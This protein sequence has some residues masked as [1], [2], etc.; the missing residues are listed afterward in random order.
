[1]P[2][3]IEMPTEPPP[4]PQ[5]WLSI[6]RQVL[7]NSGDS[8]TSL[9]A[10]GC[11]FYATLSLFP[12]LTALISVY[13]LAFDVQTAESQLHV[14]KHILPSAAYD[15]IFDRVHALV[16]Q[17]QSS[18]TLGLV[19][20]VLVALWSVTASS[21]SILS[22]LN[23]VYHTKEARGFLHFQCLAF[24]TTLMAVIGACLTLAL[25]VAAPAV[26]DYLPRY[27][28]YV[29][30]TMDNFPPSLHFLVEQGT[31][32]LVHWLAPAIM[33]CFVFTAL[34]VLYR[35]APCREHLTSWR[36]IMPGALLATLLWVAVSIG[37]SWYVSHFASYGTTYGPLGAVA[38]VMM[39]LFVSAYVVLFGAVLNAEL[40]ERGYRRTVRKEMGVPADGAEC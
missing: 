8:Q 39:W 32:V 30:V 3:K 15:M 25:M 5:G 19:F 21:K 14:V 35:I 16:T 22:A 20:S 28:S 10:A 23:I 2:D 12:A 7:S 4:P 31:P 9:S 6:F 40:E 13:G 18:L 34:I 24:G 33:L 36:W 26:V 1:M 29:G 37:F 11:A 27:L 38:A 17:P